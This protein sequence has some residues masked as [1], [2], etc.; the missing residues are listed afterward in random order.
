MHAMPRRQQFFCRSFLGSLSVQNCTLHA[1]A[2]VKASLMMMMMMIV[3]EMPSAA[4]ATAY[5]AVF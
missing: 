4:Q 5:V 3:L 1:H 2:V